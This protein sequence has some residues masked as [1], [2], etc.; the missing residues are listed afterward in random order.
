MVRENELKT[1]LELHKRRPAPD[2]TVTGEQIQPEQNV[3][4]IVANALNPLSRGNSFL[5]PAPN[6]GE[7]MDLAEPKLPELD[8]ELA[9]VDAQINISASDRLSPRQESSN[10]LRQLRELRQK[11]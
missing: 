5:V 3:N 8:K 9:R 2:P 7:Q 6:P 1:L 10:W 11:I 4:K